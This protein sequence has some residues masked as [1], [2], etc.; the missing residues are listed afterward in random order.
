MGIREVNSGPVVVRCPVCRSGVVESVGSLVGV[1]LGVRFAVLIF[2]LA[3]WC[4]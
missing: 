2:A 1:A 3:G 4:R